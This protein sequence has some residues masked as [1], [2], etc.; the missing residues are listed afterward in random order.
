MTAK[1][2]HEVRFY[3]VLDKFQTESEILQDRSVGSLRGV[4]KHNTNL[5]K[6]LFLFVIYDQE[7]E[8]APQPVAVTYDSSQF[9]RLRWKRDGKFQGNNFSGLKLSAKCGA[10]AVLREFIRPPPIGDRR[11]FAEDR[12]LNARVETIA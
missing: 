10:N 5:A 9:H 8:S 7:F 11:S 12:E 4:G 6:H 3:T 2:P 1:R